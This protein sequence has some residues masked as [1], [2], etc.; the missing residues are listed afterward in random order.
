MKT[1]NVKTGFG[2]IT[3]KSGNIHSK[4]ILPIGEHPCQDEFVYIEVA[5]QKALDAI[6][7]YQ[8][9]AKIEKAEI[10]RR[11]SAVTRSIA[12]AELIKLG[13]LPPDYKDS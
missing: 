1:I 3:D 6:E 9:P 11:I 10:E 5:D 12:I 13:E 8:D 2:Y 4:S 7:I